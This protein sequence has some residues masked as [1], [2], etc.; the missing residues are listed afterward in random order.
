[1]SSCVNPRAWVVAKLSV[2]LA[3]SSYCPH[4]SSRELLDSPSFLDP[5]V[6][7]SPLRNELLLKR[8]TLRLSFSSQT[9]NTQTDF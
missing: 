6:E 3:G 2:C 7:I 9:I 8:N 5:S 1:M 4:L